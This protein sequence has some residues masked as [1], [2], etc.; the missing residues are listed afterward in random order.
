MSPDK[1]TQIQLYLSDS[2]PE[3]AVESIQNH[4]LQ[5]SKREL[6]GIIDPEALL[7]MRKT[8]RSEIDLQESRIKK[9]KTA[10]TKSNKARQSNVKKWNDFVVEISEIMAKYEIDLPDGVPVHFTHGKMFIEKLKNSRPDIG[11]YA[12][13]RLPQKRDDSLIDDDRIILF[14]SQAKMALLQEI[15]ER[16]S[17][18]MKHLFDNDAE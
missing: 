5:E 16:K 10:H 17:K 11:T 1:A 12:G 9:L 15:I 3:D 7:S 14:R 2:R 4:I 13:L 18:A 8:I 6:E